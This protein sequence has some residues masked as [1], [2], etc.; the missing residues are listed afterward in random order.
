MLSPLLPPHSLVH[1]PPAS[2]HLPL[3]T[4]PWGD[5]CPQAA[6]VQQGTMAASSADPAGRGHP[7]P[8]H[9]CWS[10]EARLSVGPN[11]G[12]GPASGPLLAQAWASGSLWGPPWVPGPCRLAVGKEQPPKEDS[13]SFSQ[14]LVLAAGQAKTTGV[15]Q[16]RYLPERNRVP[17]AHVHF[18][19]TPQPGS[20][21]LLWEWLLHFLPVSLTSRL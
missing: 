2:P 14:K 9:S 20:W 3:P 1:P 19:A 11:W 18:H 8:Q 17:A 15:R 12:L 21:Q 7:S 5:S 13:R 10:P 16:A 4:G 6:T